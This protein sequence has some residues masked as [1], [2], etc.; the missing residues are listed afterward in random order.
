MG[1][2]ERTSSFSPRKSWLELGYTGRTKDTSNFK[3]FEGEQRKN[4]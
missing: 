3:S 2:F 4:P 1:I